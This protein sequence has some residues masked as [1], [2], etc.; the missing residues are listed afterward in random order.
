MKIS[1]LLVSHKNAPV[2]NNVEELSGKNVYVL[3]L[4]VMILNLSYMIFFAE[5]K[6]KP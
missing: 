4:L 3:N 5:V 1:E 6:V 2:I